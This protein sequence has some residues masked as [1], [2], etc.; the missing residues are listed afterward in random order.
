MAIILLPP[1]GEDNV[2]PRLSPT[3][4]IIFSSSLMAAIF[5][6]AATRFFLLK[7]H[8]GKGGNARQKVIGGI[9]YL[10]V[11]TSFLAFLSTIG[12]LVAEMKMG[13]SREV[14]TS[15]VNEKVSDTP[16]PKKY[17]GH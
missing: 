4:L 13:A 7:K 11:L 2:D 12:T 1:T 17:V 10:S 16:R 5:I 8:Q 9:Y 14:L 15:M 3:T 6:L